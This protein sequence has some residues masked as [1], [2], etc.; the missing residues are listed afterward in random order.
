M[1]TSP[2]PIKNSIK[3]TEKSLP[4]L[5]DVSKAKSGDSFLYE[6]ETSND[7]I[8]NSVSVSKLYGDL[9]DGFSINIR[10]YSQHKKLVL[11]HAMT[12]PIKCGQRMTPAILYPN[13][14]CGINEKSLGRLISVEILVMSND[15]NTEISPQLFVFAGFAKIHQSG[16]FAD[17]ITI[18]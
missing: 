1:I 12:G 5:F 11:D 16:N 2:Q 6:F 14:N 3:P 13:D 18:C 4:F 9:P 8:L 7:L 15:K 10:I 17:V